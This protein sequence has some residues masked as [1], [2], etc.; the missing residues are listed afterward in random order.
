MRTSDVKELIRQRFTGQASAVFFEVADATGFNGTG[1][2]D[3]ISMSLWPS[4]GLELQ[5]FEIKVSRGDWKREL[6]NPLKAEKFALRCDRWWLV[7]AQCVV[8]DEDE[9]PAN[10]G[11]MLATPDGLQIKRKAAKNEPLPLDRDFLAA[12][13]RSAGKIDQSVIEAMCQK[14]VKEL[15][16]H[17]ERNI[18][19]EIDRRANRATEDTKIMTE[20]RKAL[21]A[22]NEFTFLADESIIA[23][24]LAVH[25]SGVST[26]WAGLSYAAKVLEDAA[27]KIRASHASLNLPKPKVEKKRR[28]A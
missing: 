24:I 6:A 3:A 5:G 1:W 12:L 21:T 4:H 25:K 13:L 9:I 7:S 11:W 17:D 27:E 8:E 26:T 19:Y 28:R 14:R 18:Q 20:L 16:E 15:R 23:A 22:E 2:A 10:W